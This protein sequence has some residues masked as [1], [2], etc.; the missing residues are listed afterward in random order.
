MTREDYK[1]IRSQEGVV[2]IDS[3]YPDKAALVNRLITFNLGLPKP[4]TIWDSY[5]DFLRALD[6]LPADRRT[7]HEVMFGDIPQKLKF[8]I[9]CESRDELDFDAM[10]TIIIETIKDAFLVCYMADLPREDIIV[11]KTPYDGRKYSAHIILM[12]AVSNHQQGQQ[13]TEKVLSYLPLDL[14]RIVDTTANNAL[15][16][17][18]CVYCHKADDDVARTK[19]PY[20]LFG[21][22]L[23]RAVDTFV[24]NTAGV[25]LMPDVF[26]TKQKREAPSTAAVD[27]YA[28]EI[29]ALCDFPDHRFR[30]VRGDLLL[31]DRIRPS[32]CNICKKTHTHDNTLIVSAEQADKKLVVY[33]MCRRNM[34]RKRKIGE[35][36]NN[37]AAAS[38][39]A[40]VVASLPAAPGPVR[41]KFDT[42]AASQ[43][44]IYESP[45]LAPFEP[46]DLLVVRAPMKMGKTKMLRAHI[47]AHFAE[48]NAIIR[49]LSFRQTFSNTIKQKFPE[50][51]LYSD[52]VG[53]LRDNR[54]IIQIESL[55]R[56]VLEDDP[57]DLLV[58]DECESI[59]DQFAGG[60]AR[61]KMRDC[62]EKFKYLIKYSRHV[63]CMDAGV[64]D[65]SYNILKSLLPNFDAPDAD[66]VYHYNTYLNARDDTYLLCET[67]EQWYTSL[68][69]HIADGNHVA[70]PCS[71]LAE[72]KTLE[73]LL[74]QKNSK[75]RIHTYSSETTQKER[76]EHF[77][78]V[79]MHWKDI[80]VMI[81]TP[82][83][84]AGVSFEVKHFDVMFCYF[85][86]ASCGVEAARQMIGR[87]RDVKSRHY[88]V[89]IDKFTS[90][91]PI[92]REEI[93]YGVIARRNGLYLSE[94]GLDYEYDA[95][96]RPAYVRTEFYYMWLENKL[97]HNLS[98]RDFL[99]RFAASVRQDGCKVIL[100]DEPTDEEIM[101]KR[102][103]VN[104][105]VK[106]ELATRVANAPEI[107]PE[108]AQQIEREAE[109]WHDIS[110]EDWKAFTKFN[111]RRHYGYTVGAEF[112]PHSAP[113]TP[114]WVITY[115][116]QRV[117]QI[118]QRRWE[119]VNGLA[120]LQKKEQD[121][122]EA[123]NGTDLEITE[124]YRYPEHRAATGLLRCL[125]FDS[126]AD[127]K[128]L[129]ADSIVENI[130]NSKY[131]DLMSEAR[132]VFQGLSLISH[133]TSDPEPMIAA[134]SRV[135]SSM[136]GVSIRS[137]P[138]MR[139]V[140]K[141]RT[142]PLFASKPG[143]ERPYVPEMKIE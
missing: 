46:C 137:E 16:N 119:L 127:P 110:D 108:Q 138:S 29:L 8:D 117:K 73:A 64:S 94:S 99:T 20:D 47:D 49:F 15:K 30:N 67:R 142:E 13:F 45:T 7:Y 122:Y 115:G 112:F 48:S 116:E 107:S 113:M 95:R 41:L 43:K 25:Q 132:A 52:V 34:T 104:K 86:G 79:D 22:G 44:H 103:E 23:P 18:R 17:M 106:L 76:R 36:A 9:D 72:A 100:N 60:L 32:M 123:K 129:H 135:N 130:K 71:S 118:F 12:R 80:D 74:G 70:V 19:A 77:A 68:F 31:F 101:T 139:Q 63:I 2:S 54:L 89:Y 66:T 93:E 141:L 81:Y 75:L 105:S 11:C 97:I 35:L 83:I 128:L 38:R 87:I 24:T 21:V 42:L 120:T 88:Y 96:G 102:A 131:W 4:Y 1:L 114:D 37:E 85:T 50:F 5:D 56:L 10:L 59:F 51:T 125:G 90:P 133:G 61:E 55:Y 98:R 58:L 33:E 28:R 82:T 62:Y 26:R 92:T 6:E 111:L 40:D 57:P 143:G 3:V 65:R 140:Y 39:L 53:E 84:T 136:Y 27:T 14:C 91:V 124:H 109:A 134:V 78:D 126:I 121:R 69:A